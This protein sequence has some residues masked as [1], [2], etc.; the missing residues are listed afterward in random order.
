MGRHSKQKESQIGQKGVGRL[1]EAEYIDLNLPKDFPLRGRGG[2][3]HPPDTPITKLH[4]H[5][6]GCLE[7]GYCHAGS[8]LFAVEDKVFPY[9]AGDV[10]VINDRELH[11]AHGARGVR[12]EW[13]FLFFDPRRLV[14]AQADEPGILDIAPLGGPAF[15]NV[16]SGKDHS[17][18]VSITR[19]M[20]HEAGRREPGFRSALKGL[21][22]ALMARLHRL[23]GLGS[24]VQV[25]PRH[26]GISRMAPALNEMTARFGEPLRMGVLAKL[27]FVSLPH[28]RRLFLEA[29][30][31]TPHRYL[32]NLRIQMAATLLEQ[33]N[34]TVLDIAMDAGYP[35][36]SSFNRG[37]RAV[38][39]VTPR[40]W[41]KRRGLVE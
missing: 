32:T 36:L 29:T 2:I 9:R 38:M 34:R 41:R 8:G 21:V 4:L 7:I 23:R 27:C 20:L 30:G 18:L 19:D 37:F 6:P 24:S 22:M 5:S 31:K 33:T 1:F 16:L 39:G 40:E 12:T 3:Y 10:S 25:A 17:E 26:T 13:S 11:V 15:P 28:F 14:G 35:T